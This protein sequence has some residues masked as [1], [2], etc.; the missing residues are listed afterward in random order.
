MLF[1]FLTFEL[2]AND[3]STS[4]HQRV[5]DRFHVGSERAD[6]PFIPLRVRPDI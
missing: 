6:L 5:C 3:H 2:T 4:E 1:S